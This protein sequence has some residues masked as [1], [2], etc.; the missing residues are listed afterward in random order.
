[1][2][3]RGIRRISRQVTYGNVNVAA[4]ERHVIRTQRVQ[5]ASDINRA[6]ARRLRSFGRR[7]DWAEHKLQLHLLQQ[8][9]C[10]LDLTACQSCAG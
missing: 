10:V 1:L 7:I 8:S 4:A 6:L 3:D 5:S 2:L 9:T